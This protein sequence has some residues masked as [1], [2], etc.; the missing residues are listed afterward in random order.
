MTLR[1]I[2]FTLLAAAAVGAFAA[3]NPDYDYEILTTASG[4]MLYGYPLVHNSD[5]SM[6]FKSF[7]ARRHIA[8]DSVTSVFGRTVSRENLSE[9]ISEGLRQ[10]PAF[11]K[12]AGTGDIRIGE[13]TLPGKWGNEF[14]VEREGSD[15]F[16]IL[17]FEQA[18]DTLSYEMITRRAS[19]VVPKD[20]DYGLLDKV[21]TARRVYSGKI[22]ERVPSKHILIW[23]NGA[24]QEIPIDNV[25]ILEKVPVDTAASVVSQSPF[26]TTFYF[27]DGSTLSGVELMTDYLTGDLDVMSA[28]DEKIYRKNLD[29]IVR[30]ENTVNPAY[31]PK[32]APKLD[33]SDGKIYADTILIAELEPKQ[34]KGDKVDF[35]SDH[36]LK[37]AATVV[38]RND[39]G[40]LGFSHK[41]NLKN[42]V[43]LY[44]VS[45]PESDRSFKKSELIGG[46]APS[47]IEKESDGRTVIV[48]DSIDQGIYM[49][50]FLSDNRYY[51][52]DIR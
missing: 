4:D 21:T 39:M 5:G 42:V 51:V 1:N 16:H 46:V 29:N 48:F 49:L 3:V 31:P 24:G 15:G 13:C 19:R 27:D 35:N 17:T 18:V 52:I 23:I 26:L 10:F 36:M 40:G 33:Y 34:T 37:E 22:I 25:N 7:A 2:S 32:R 9:D 38:T 14:I 12:D 43:T 47:S 50:S 8:S 28:S 44:R 45:S 11:A 20:Q 6:V 41:A 30:R